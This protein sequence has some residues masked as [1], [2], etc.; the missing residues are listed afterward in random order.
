LSNTSTVSSTN[1]DGSLKAG[2]IA[3][4][5]IA[6]VLV[7]E[8]VVVLVIC[9][10][11]KRL[12]L[13][14]EI[15]VREEPSEP[16]PDRDDSDQLPAVPGTS[17]GSENSRHDLE[18]SSTVGMPEGDA[19]LESHALTTLSSTEAAPENSNTY[20]P[21]SGDRYLQLPVLNLHSSNSVVHC[22]DIELGNNYFSA[23][24]AA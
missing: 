18:V 1:D 12:R 11:V 16:L 10:P 6:V 14:T 17:F 8:V 19:G 22:R 3:G 15:P 7:A 21:P 4:I 20:T 2:K 24:S 13:P 5:G 9:H 23:T